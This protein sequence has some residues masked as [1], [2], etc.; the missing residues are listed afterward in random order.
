MRTLIAFCIVGV[1]CCHGAVLDIPAGDYNVTD[2]NVGDLAA[3]DTVNLVDE[4]SRLVFDLASDASLGCLITNK[5]SVVKK[6]AGK[7]TLTNGSNG[8]G[9]KVN[10]GWHV[11]NGVLEFPKEPTATS[12]S[13]SLEVK[14]PG[15]FCVPA[16]TSGSVSSSIKF[17][18][19]DGWVTNTIVKSGDSSLEEIKPTGEF[20]GVISRYMR[21]NVPGNFNMYGKSDTA[22]NNCII[23]SSAIYGAF[24]VAGIGN[25]Y[26]VLFN[27]TG[28]TL[29]YLGEGGDVFS[30][31]R[32]VSNGY[33]N[34]GIDGGECGGLTVKPDTLSVS[35]KVADFI[36]KGD[37]GTNIYDAASGDVT[38]STGRIVKKGGCAW[39]FL[40]NRFRWKNCGS[41]EVN[42]GK[43][44]IDY[45]NDSAFPCPL[46]LG[47][48]PTK[49][50]SGNPAYSSAY[51]VPYQVLLSGG[52]LEYVG[53]TNQAFAADRGVGVSADSR[54]TDNGSARFGFDGVSC[55]GEE[56]RTLTLGGESDLSHL[57]NIT[58]GDAALSLEKDGGGTWTLGGELSFSG[59]LH[60]KEGKVVV[61]A[62]SSDSKYTWFR[63][64]VMDNAK[65]LNSLNGQNVQINQW[66]LFDANSNRI[67]RTVKNSETFG[68]SNL[69]T[70]EVGWGW[71]AELFDKQDKAD[72]GTPKGMFIE[73]NYYYY[74]KQISASG[75]ERPRYDNTNTWQRFVVRFPQDTPE[76]TSYDIATPFTNN[77]RCVIAWRIDGSR[78]GFHWDVLDEQYCPPGITNAVRTS[79]HWVYD[80]SDVVVGT[81]KHAGFPIRGHAE[82]VVVAEQLRNATVVV[83][84]GAELAADG[85]VE[86]S[87]LKVDPATGA[88]TLRG[89]SFAA[90]GVLELDE[91]PLSGVSFQVGVAD[92]EDFA[93]VSKWTVEVDGMVQGGYRIS[94]LADGRVSVFPVGTM[95]IVR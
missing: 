81:G 44:I 15:V 35:A 92:S 26:Q 14:A 37:A 55:V 4:T 73:G 5:G 71:N 67:G 58:D 57:F 65:A 63:L 23:G 59:K 86:I 49:P 85:S 34:S 1:M 19:G 39:R 77:S 64:N 94:A 40:H 51:D 83:D 89:F 62:D 75:G 50:A 74:Q 90:A 10:G 42:E 66:G 32:L 30:G 69:Q 43:L 84:P 20:S 48:Q 68:T 13:Y 78:D 9:F 79:K 41:V 8:N 93:D 87:R 28:S 88:G 47:T 38:G 60:V 70:N 82:N 16:K 91:K 95:V 24:T 53:V 7:L 33:N 56:P 52:E 27:G 21:Q 46:G 36:F 45:L 6:G 18:G 12:F 80:V 3:Y 76:I 61:K 2:A 17:L 54:I 31:K 72:S 25:A 29:K 11:E 22:G